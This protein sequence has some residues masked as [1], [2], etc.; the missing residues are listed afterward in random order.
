MTEQNQDNEMPEITKR[1]SWRVCLAAII[2][3]LTAII[4][5]FLWSEWY[6]KS[7]DERLAEIEAARAIPDSEN[8]AVIYYQLATSGGRT[9]ARPGY[10]D[11][12]D[13]FKF[14]RPW[15]GK[16]YP[17][18]AAWLEDQQDVIGDLL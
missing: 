8:A 12:R 15:R 9:G 3:V 2:V 6:G 4:A 5:C 10:S 7:V 11:A 14:I 13:T 18:V 1:L 16:D 17:K